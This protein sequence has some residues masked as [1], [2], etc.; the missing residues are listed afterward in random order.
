MDFFHK[1]RQ[2]TKQMRDGAFVFEFRTRSSLLPGTTSHKFILTLNFY[3][4]F[5]KL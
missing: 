3:H 1:T 5:K 2:D 4:L